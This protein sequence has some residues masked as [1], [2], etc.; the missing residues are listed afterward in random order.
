MKLKIALA[1][2]TFAVILGLWSGTFK[3]W[4]TYH[5]IKA[6]N[7]AA[8]QRRIQKED[9][10]RATILSALDQVH[11]STLYGVTSMCMR[12]PISDMMDDSKVNKYSELSQPDTKSVSD[13][14]K[15]GLHAHENQLAP[16]GLDCWCGAQYI[17]R[18]QAQ[19]ETYD[20]LPC[21]KADSMEIY[22]NGHWL[23][24]LSFDRKSLNDLGQYL[25]NAK[26][27]DPRPEIQLNISK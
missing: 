24:V 26:S 20:L 1:L 12:K 15:T 14:F 5:N 13:E 6:H 23:N 19:S 25:T 21:S 16:M 7:D 27:P 8:Q 22:R 17:L 3:G 18:I 9:A 2:I 10:L 11:S 4:V